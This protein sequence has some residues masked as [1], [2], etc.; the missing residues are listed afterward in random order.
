MI[1]L[2]ASWMPLPEFLLRRSP[3]RSVG[4]YSSSGSAD[5]GPRVVKKVVIDVIEH[6]ILTKMNEH[7]TGNPPHDQQPFDAPTA[8]KTP[9][10]KVLFMKLITLLI[11]VFHGS[12][13]EKWRAAA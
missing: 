13:S 6:A 9:V 4:L 12:S 10:R 3:R 5:P 7:H 8:C 11:V 2:V 1:N